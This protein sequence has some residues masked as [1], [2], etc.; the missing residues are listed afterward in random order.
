MII[1]CG[2]CKVKYN[3]SDHELG[4]EGRFVRCTACEHEWL[5]QLPISNS[6]VKQN[7]TAYQENKLS[8]TIPVKNVY[9][10]QAPS[11]NIWLRTILIITLVVV[12]SVLYFIIN[13]PRLNLLKHPS[14]TS[15]SLPRFF[16][17]GDNEQELKVDQVSYI[18]D[19]K[20]HD[21]SK[22]KKHKIKLKIQNSS[23]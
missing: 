9:K 21:N 20:I 6:E 16:G 2:N 8:N 3:V 10:C 14:I 23:S 15:Y 4:T 13:I 5:V 12:L 11:S 19:D 18:I 22:S 7:Y 1:V 17:L